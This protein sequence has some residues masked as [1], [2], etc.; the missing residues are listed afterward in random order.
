M[1]DFEICNEECTANET[2]INLLTFGLLQL[3]SELL[4]GQLL[5]PVTNN[6]LTKLNNA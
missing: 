6:K 1:N 3:D 2:P 5:Q 4:F